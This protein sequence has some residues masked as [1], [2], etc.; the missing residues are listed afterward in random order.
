MK[1]IIILVL[2]LILFSSFA[3]AEVLH[4]WWPSA[5]SS[6]SYNWDGCRVPLTAPNNVIMGDVYDSLILPG[7]TVNV[8]SFGHYN[9]RCD[10][11]AGT[12]RN[13]YYAVDFDRSEMYKT[14]STL[15]NG[16]G[17]SRGTGYTS[18]VGSSGSYREGPE[19]GYG[20]NDTISYTFIDINQWT[21]GHIYEAILA[22]PA[23]A[24]TY[25][26]LNTIK[27]TER[28]FFAPSPSLL[29]FGEADNKYTYF[30]DEGNYQTTVFFT[31]VN[32]FPLKIRLKYLDLIC[33]PGLTCSAIDSRY[34]AGDWLVTG[35]DGV[36]IIPIDVTFSKDDVGAVYNLQMDANFDVPQL[37]GDDTCNPIYATHSKPFSL[38]TRLIDK[39]DIQIELIASKEQSQCIG[40]DGVVGQTGPGFAPKINIGFGG[41]I[42]SNGNL[43]AMDECDA[44]QLDNTEN[45]DGVYC[46][47]K[48]F[49]V[50]IGRKI[51]KIYDA[52]KNQDHDAIR[53]YSTF[54]T[55]M[56]TQDLSQTHIQNS[57]NGMDALTEFNPLNIGLQGFYS[58]GGFNTTDKSKQLA[59]ITSLYENVTFKNTENILDTSTLLPK[60]IYTVNID[61]IRVSEDTTN[62]LFNTNDVFNSNYRVE[63]NFSNTPSGP[64]TSGLDWF[65]YDYANY[66]IDDDLINVDN[67][68]SMYT[69]NV[70]RRG[71]TFTF[72]HN[73]STPDINKNTLYKS[74]ATPFFIRVNDVNA[75]KI[76]IENYASTSDTLTY[77]T[78]F[79]SNKGSGCDNIF[80]GDHEEK[81]VPYYRADVLESGGN[82][83]YTLTDANTSLTN[84][85]MYLETTM[86]TP[87][88]KTPKLDL[89]MPFNAY[90]ENTICDGNKDSPCLL[91]IDETTNPTLHQAN[92]LSE[93]F[94]K[95]E[96]GE[97]CVH[98]GQVGSDTMWNIFWNE[99]KILL[100]L[101][102]QKHAITDANLCALRLILDTP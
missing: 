27:L 9:Y 41:G 39:Q 19:L 73:P 33:P 77:W 83:I 14:V 23:Y 101:N 5:S 78:G 43:I 91:T 55:Y 60:G 22:N 64:A 10:N 62:N 56:R 93:I 95:I 88:D 76:T 7:A 70:F 24:G 46:S 42:D 44:T 12:S 37:A 31:I 96:T 16:P 52:T 26:H 45:T 1:K 98:F 49:L 38:N 85:I 89:S 68:D 87:S 66:E 28:F 90:T 6:P 100:D 86:Y 40:L 13:A 65:F 54:T 57:I 63:V 47:Q 67:S 35:N 80:V 58:V 34:T 59:R 3:S 17:A 72:T 18:C 21:G 82:G 102:S 32:K 8:T 61:L 11:G 48:E 2:L 29:V 74:F 97:M 99:Q 69:T 50:E 51:A 25:N 81:T 92:D 84:G 4:C 71:T 75:K 36:L 20:P 94:N 53:D 15:T 79:A 30:E